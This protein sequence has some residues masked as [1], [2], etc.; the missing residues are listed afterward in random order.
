MRNV[1]GAIA[2][3]EAAVADAGGRI[4]DAERRIGIC[5]AAA[6]ILGPL[7]EGGPGR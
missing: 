1:D 3:A 2:A 7:A 5:E 4:A 6:Y